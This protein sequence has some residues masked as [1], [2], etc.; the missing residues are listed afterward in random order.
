MGKRTALAFFLS[1]LVIIGYNYYL[2]KKYPPKPLLSQQVQPQEVG[3]ETVLPSPTLTKPAPSEAQQFLA[4]AEDIV[5]E[6]DRAKIIITSSGARIKSYQ[7]KNYPEAKVV[8]SAVNQ[9]LAQL[10]NLITRNGQEKSGLWQRQ[11][12]K[13]Q[14]LLAK[15]EQSPQM[16]ELVSLAAVL[17]ADFSP[18][19]IIPGNETI[20]QKFNSAQ[21][22]FSQQQLKLDPNHPQGTITFSYTD[23]QGRQLEKS[24]HFDNS[25]YIMGLDIKLHGFSAADF[26]QNSFLVSVGPD[27]GLEQSSQDKK[28]QSYHGPVTCF[29]N[30]QQKWVR[31]EKFTKQEAAL[32]VRRELSEGTV[33]WTG[34]ENKYFLA[35]LIPGQKP[36]MA[37]VE[38][39]EQEHK[40]AL[41]MSLVSD[42]VYPFRLYMGPKKKSDLKTVDATLGKTIDYGLFSPI[43]KLIYAALVLFSRWTGNFGWAIILL[44]IATKVVFHPLTHRS[45]EAMQKMQEQMKTIQPELEAL[46]L[47]Y[48]DNPQRL[49]KEIMEFYKKKGVNPMASCQSGCLPM[50]LQMPVFFALYAVLYNS[51]ELRGTPFIGW[52]TDLSDKDPYYVLPIL[53]GVSMYIQQKLTGLGTTGSAQQDQAKMMAIMM[54]VM[55]TWVFASLPSGVVLYW[56]TFNIVTAAHQ[57]LLKKKT[58]PAVGA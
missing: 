5:V 23:P 20:S 51:I 12:N 22:R 34:L 7:L 47:K 29:D 17:D 32:F 26:P 8:S 53:M 50:L 21:Y 54:P 46:R 27:V 44:C 16:A 56:L 42:N 14:T 24:Y 33:V 15:Y 13:L 37:V 31:T 11:K 10:D 48:K 52:I 35:A 45:F 58:V 2:A 9:Q 30:G 55:L 43:A 57:M 49:N 1:L 4:G 6:T 40:T 25:N 19:F 39:N 3:K 28:M 38:K 18:A 41:Q 36:Q